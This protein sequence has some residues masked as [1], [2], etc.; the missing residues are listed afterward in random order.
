LKEVASALQILQ[1]VFAQIKQLYILWESL[2]NQLMCRLGE[3]YLSTV[4]GT[5]DARGM[6][7]IQTHVALSSKHWFTRMQAHAYPHRHAIWPG[8][9][10]KGTLSSR[11]SHDGIGGAGKGYEEGIPLSVDLVSIEGMKNVPEQIT[12]LCQRDGIL[13]PSQALE[14]VGRALDIGEEQ[15]DGSCWMRLH[16]EPPYRGRTDLQLIAPEGLLSSN[17]ICVSISQFLLLILLLL[18]FLSGDILPILE[19]C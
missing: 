2:Y 15:G 3:Q 5:H 9:G 17:N 7:H 14:Q 13:L 11:C 4:G 10:E 16:R 1:A 8:M 12:L 18:E 19:Y 6:M